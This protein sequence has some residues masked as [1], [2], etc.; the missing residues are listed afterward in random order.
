[1]ANEQTVMEV[2]WIPS[3][4]VRNHDFAKNGIFCDVILMTSPKRRHN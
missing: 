2:E 3:Y 1:L 4:Q